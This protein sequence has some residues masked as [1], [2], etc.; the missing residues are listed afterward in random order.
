MRAGG[1]NC[2]QFSRIILISS[3]ILNIIILLKI[4]FND[5]RTCHPQQVER[6]ELMTAEVSI[7]NNKPIWTM[8]LDFEQLNFSNITGN[9]NG[10]YIVPNYVHFVRFGETP[11]TYV[12]MICIL[13][14][15]KNQKPDKIFFH[16]DHN[17][18]YTGQYWE[19]LKNTKGFMDTVEFHYFP[20]PTEIFGQTLSTGWRYWHGGDL[21]RI[22]ILMKY[23]GI[24][25]DNDSYLVKSLDNFRKYEITLNWDENQY[26]ASQLVVAHKDARF[27]KE[28]LNTYKVYRSD[29]WYYNAGERPTTEVLYKR[30]E[31]I[32]R[33]KVWFGADNKYIHYL[34]Q[35]QWAEWRN[36]Y[37]LHLLYRHQYLLH[38]ISEKATF[39]VELNEHNIGDYPITFREMAYDVYDI[40]A[41]TWPKKT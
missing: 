22:Q 34:F 4:N 12:E 37:A 20:L 40:A 33:V 35:Q 19:I 7:V 8:D 41:I 1:T 3:I 9:P 27:L 10:C 25:I 38:N 31:L 39:P 18:S 2:H 15:F 36:F 16:R 11:I 24:Y 29:R 6:K 14:A 5:L 28:W 30:P 32:H 23:G 21:A 17:N 26:L 13:A